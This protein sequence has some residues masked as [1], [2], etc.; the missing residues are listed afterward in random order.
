MASPAVQVTVSGFNGGSLGLYL[1]RTVG[2]SHT[3]T[4]GLHLDEIILHAFGLMVVLVRGAAASVER[5]SLH[6]CTTHFTARGSREAE[7]AQRRVR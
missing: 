7:S 3:M 1:Y 4:R 5:P 2:T 6:L